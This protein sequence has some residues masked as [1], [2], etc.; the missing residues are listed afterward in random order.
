[1]FLWIELDNN[2]IINSSKKMS[3]MRDDMLKENRALLKACLEKAQSI[4]RSEFINSNG[5]FSLVDVF[6]TDFLKFLVY[7]SLA[8]GVVNR[9][10][11]KF[12][13][14]NLGYE[15]TTE[16]LAK[17]GVNYKLNSDNF[18]KT[19]PQS[20]RYF[21][22]GNNGV[23]FSYGIRYYNLIKLYCSTFHGVGR[24]LI[25]CNSSVTQEEID[26][27][28]KY[29]IMLEQHVETIQEEWENSRES[30]SYKVKKENNLTKEVDESDIPFTGVIV[31]ADDSKTI[32]DLYRDLLGLTGLESV[33]QEVG[34]L[35]N[36]IRISKIREEQ[37]LNP[38]PI[39]MHL[40]FLGNPG[41]GKTTVARILAKIYNSLGILSK[42][43]MVEVDR[44]GLVAGYMGQT[45]QKVQGVIEKAKGGVLFIDEAYALSV[46]KSEG[47][48][49]QEAIDIL[50]KA[51]EDYR[52]DLIVIAAGYG[53]EM[54]IFLD[55][56]PGLRSRFN[57]YITFPD[58]NAE[59]L[60]EILVNNANKID[61]KIDEEAKQ[62][63]KEEYNKILQN[64]PQNFG[65]ARAVRNYL[66]KAIS[67][68]ANR[69][70][71]SGSVDKESLVTLTI[72][73]IKDVSLE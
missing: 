4:G 15:F 49:G 33:K 47:D 10:E 43:Q 16:S 68:Q 2:A 29:S 57:R 66:D 28:T 65:N 30:I 34:N 52:D 32:D 11:V 55:A 48:F 51:M 42:G 50:N 37:G 31:E 19:I 40:V 18:L 58:Y 53:D 38:P 7:L 59:E 5:T 17:Y 6:R 64:A 13:N 36:L 23:E 71:G 12:I 56:N 22:K 63:I 21:V 61:Y 70:I 67:N 46:N 45:A 54:Q 20:L 24:E 44:S 73:D 26:A 9:E 69:L 60:L 1:M 39:D 35:V 62:S 72:D 14:T 27:L 3:N 8:D 41:T 25:A